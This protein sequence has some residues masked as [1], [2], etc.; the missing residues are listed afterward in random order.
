MGRILELESI[1][2]ELPK[3]ESYSENDKMLLIKD[4]VGNE[5]KWYL[6][7]RGWEY[8]LWYTIC[9]RGGLAE[10]QELTVLINNKETVMSI[11]EYVKRYRKLIAAA[12]PSN[13]IF[14][15]FNVA[16]KA[17]HNKS[18]QHDYYKEK[19][20]NKY[21]KEHK[22][23]IVK[24][25]ENAIYYEKL[26]TSEE[27]LYNIYQDEVHDEFELVLEFTEKENHLY[28][29]QENIIL[30]PFEYCDQAVMDLPELAI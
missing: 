24:E 3:H 14:D 23:D 18:I 1:V 2:Y 7:S 25:T 12:K 26:I 5:P 30:K 21:M 13:E 10:A 16:A 27:E 17:W 6:A 19:I 11:E 22:M 29:M 4:T 28:N 9:K 8:S 20:P 15:K